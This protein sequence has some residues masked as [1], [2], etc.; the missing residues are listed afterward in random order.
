MRVKCKIRPILVI[1]MSV[2]FEIIDLSS[3]II[4]NIKS[5]F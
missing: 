3:T 4:H 1:I 5:Q 2:E